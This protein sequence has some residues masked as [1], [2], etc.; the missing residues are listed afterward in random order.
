MSVP[1][2][3]F[4]TVPSLE[5]ASKVADALVAEHLAACVGIVEGIRSVYF[6]KDE[7]CR[8]RET[9]L[10]IKTTEEVYPMMEQRLKALHP[11][12]VPEIVRLPVTGGWPPYLAWIG[13]CVN[14]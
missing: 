11:Y 13:D 9:L 5:C 3:V 6:W 7:V 2:V 4:S 8:D 14:R 12:E 10:V 1:C